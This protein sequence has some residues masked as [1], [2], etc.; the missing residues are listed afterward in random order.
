MPC[1]PERHGDIVITGVESEE[2]EEIN[3]AYEDLLDELGKVALQI[4]EIIPTM[5]IL[6]GISAGTEDDLPELMPSC[7]PLLLLDCVG[8]RLAAWSS[9]N[10]VQVA[11]H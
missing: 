5:R 11:T 9:K 1:N 7:F 8:A 6:A 2:V 4:S 10:S 3:G